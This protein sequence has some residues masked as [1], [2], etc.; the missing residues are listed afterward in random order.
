VHTTADSLAGHAFWHTLKGAVSCGC[1]YRY[2]YQSMSNYLGAG[3]WIMLESGPL[4]FS[5][6]VKIFCDKMV[7]VVSSTET[8]APSISDLTTVNSDFKW[9]CCQHLQQELDTA[10]VELKT[11]KK[12]IELLQE[13]TNS[14]APSTTANTQGRNTIY[15]SSARN[16][17]LEENTSGNW[18]KVAYTRRKYNKQS[19][20]RRRQPIPT[21]VNCFTLPDSHREESEACHF[22]GLVEK[23]AAVQTNNKCISKP[24]RNK[25][26]ILGDSHARGCAAELSASFSTP[27]EVM[28]AVMPGSRLEHI[29][30]L[31]RRE[32]IYIVITL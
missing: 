19:D 21:I 27:F 9:I 10:L 18:G 12:I 26:L 29:T 2:K 32:V 11:P 20:A 13:E 14:T 16:S 28:G 6:T 30:S 22:T 23:I 5:I 15:D 25:I 31:S 24:Q 7:A 4:Y 8:K 3:K 17:D 1:L